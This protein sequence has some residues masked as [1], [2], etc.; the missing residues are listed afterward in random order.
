MEISA[1]NPVTPPTP[2]E[3]SGSTGTFGKVMNAVQDM[4]TTAITYA[5][6]LVGA[7]IGG[8]S[9]S[10]DMQELIATQMQVQ[11]EMQVTNMVSNVEKSKHETA[12]APIRNIRVG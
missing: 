4:A 11:R 6:P 12:M 9:T 2:N 5:S 7:A 10:G 1:I 8:F 3:V